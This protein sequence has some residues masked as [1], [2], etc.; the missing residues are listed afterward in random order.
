MKM[1]VHQHKEQVG[2]NGRSLDGRARG[3]YFMWQSTWYYE[4][5]RAIAASAAGSLAL[6]R[7]GKKHELLEEP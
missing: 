6:A 5:L 3:M 4:S 1:L 2:R 7:K